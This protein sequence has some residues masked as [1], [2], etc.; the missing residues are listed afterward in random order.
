M[1]RWICLIVL[2][3]A[4]STVSADEKPKPN[5]LTQKEIEEG[6][7]LLFDGETTFG[8]KTEGDVKV[9][10]GELRLGG[11]KAASITSTAA[12]GS[13][14]I[15][16]ESTRWGEAWIT[17]CGCPRNLPVESVPLGS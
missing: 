9:E 1:C 6:W 13:C 7:I 3:V 12:F 10:E 17:V 15:V 14:E 2:G 4:A 11:E 16:L 5:T 8:W